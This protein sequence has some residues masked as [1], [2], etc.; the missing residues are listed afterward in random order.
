[1]QD[2]KNITGLRSFIKIIIKLGFQVACNYATNVNFRFYYD[3]KT[4]E[5]SRL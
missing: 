5:L 1:M 3:D 4:N 2:R